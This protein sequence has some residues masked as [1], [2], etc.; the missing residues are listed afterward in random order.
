MKILDTVVRSSLPNESKNLY[1]E[2]YYINDLI[3][4]VEKSID[5]LDFIISVS[6]NRKDNIYLDILPYGRD[7]SKKYI[8]YLNN[9]A[10]HI[11]TW[12]ISNSTNVI[13]PIMG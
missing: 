5:C 7:V 3:P 13:Q 4:I 6:I 2:D 12:N 10:L 11:N 1:I 8:L 9:S